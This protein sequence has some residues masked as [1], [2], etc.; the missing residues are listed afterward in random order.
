MAQ[1]FDLNIEEILDNWGTEH[2]IREIIA[3]ALDEMKL[4]GTASPLIRYKNSVC[5][6][7]DYGRGLEYRHFTQKENEEKLKANNVIGKYGVGLKDALGV[8]YRNNLKV[9]IHSRHAT[10]SLA[11]AAKPGFALKT[12]HAVFENPIDPEFTGTEFI[13]EGVNKSDVDKA[14]DMFLIFSNPALPAGQTKYGAVYE[15]RSDLP[16]II[17]LNG[18]KIA[19]EPNFL[20]SYNITRPSKKLSNAMNRERINVGRSAYTDSVKN[21][22]LRCSERKVTRT[23]VE[24]IRKVM[25][26]KSK[27]ETGWVDIASSAAVALNKSEKVVFTTPTLRKRMDE[28]QADILKNSGREIIFVTDAVFSKINRDVYTYENAVYDYRKSFK[29]RYVDLELLSEQEKGVYDYG[30]P[31]VDLLVRRGSIPKPDIRISETITTSESGRDTTGIW[32]SEERAIIV[33][34]TVLNNLNE[35]LSVLITAFANHTSSSNKL[36][37]KAQET[38][39]QILV[40]VYLEYLKKE[41]QN[42]AVKNL[43]FKLK[44]LLAQNKILSEKVGTL[45]TAI[46][47][48]EQVIQNF[49]TTRERDFKTYKQRETQLLKD[50][51]G[52]KTENQNLRNQLNCQEQVLQ[53]VKKAKE[54]DAVT[55][56]EKEAQLLK[57]LDG[58]KSENQYL[59]NQLSRQE[60][61]EA[62]NSLLFDKIEE[63]STSATELEIE[64][65]S[66]ETT[67]QPKP[68]KPRFFS[69]R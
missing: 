2:A 37:L 44:V 52:Y 11:M 10:I 6:I 38:I 57:D 32:S 20:F 48:N 55:F 67:T 56:E 3:N 40:F 13:I 35:Y 31:L 69:K 14:K 64:N 45:E 8:F 65:A 9:T 17:Y 24:D 5:T 51:D 50:L 43:D 60:A 15:K 46:A 42:E 16:G 26:G 19:E 29:Y 22:L 12:L 49:S 27:V 68:K 28:Q 61:L 59:R 54:E 1:Y 25:S 7:R 18:V 30:P 39:V 23:L 33:K 41:W 4:T 53:D 63:M 47:N 62:V 58:Y 66:S 36:P 34:R 21:I